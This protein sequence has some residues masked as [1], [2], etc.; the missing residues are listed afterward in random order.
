MLQSFILIDSTFLMASLASAGSVQIIWP[1]VVIIAGRSHL[2]PL[3]HFFLVIFSSYSGISVL[4]NLLQGIV[5]V[6]V[7]IFSGSCELTNRVFNEDTIQILLCVKTKLF[8]SK[9]GTSYKVMIQK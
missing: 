3:F 6:D 2:S 7:L 5:I 4:W 9:K 8:Q 1:Y